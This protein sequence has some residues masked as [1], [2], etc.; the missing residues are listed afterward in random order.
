M[1][2]SDW[3]KMLNKLDDNDELCIAR[4]S[5]DFGIIRINYAEP[6]LRKKNDIDKSWELKEINKFP[7]DNVDYLI[8]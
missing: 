6:I 2:V 8:Y 4:P 3:K 1:K 7:D 5:Q